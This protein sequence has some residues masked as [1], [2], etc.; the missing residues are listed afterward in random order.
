MGRNYWMAHLN[1]LSTI[2]TYQWWDFVK[3]SGVETECREKSFHALSQRALVQVEHKQPWPKFEPSLLFLF[4][5]LVTFYGAN[6]TPKSP[7]SWL[8]TAL[9]DLYWH[10][11]LPFPRHTC[12]HLISFKE[13]S[14]LAIWLLYSGKT[15][16]HYS[17][18]Y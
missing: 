11:T 16:F 8:V 12:T 17:I 9:L 14:M 18:F 2:V 10:L 5:L 4:S 7:V 1:T 3:I 6:V 13:I 15:Y